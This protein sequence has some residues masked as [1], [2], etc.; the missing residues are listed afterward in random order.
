ML[1]I[2]GN[3]P[4]PPAPSSRLLPFHTPTQPHFRDA[5]SPP[6][7]FLQVDYN[8][9]TTANETSLPQGV[10][11]PYDPFQVPNHPCPPRPPPPPPPSPPQATHTHTHKHTQPT[12]P[13]LAMPPFLCD[14]RMLSC[15]VKAAPGAA[16]SSAWRR[17]C[18][19]R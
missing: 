19:A 4:P 15:G 8:S 17:A 7:P 1:Q 14:A 3:H 2:R 16:P 11:A 5:S 9:L 12:K 13:R 10:A 6:L 18:T